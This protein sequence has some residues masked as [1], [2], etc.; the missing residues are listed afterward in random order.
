MFSSKDSQDDKIYPDHYLIN[1]CKQYLPLYSKIKMIKI[2]QE[3]VNEYAFPK[4]KIFQ[5]RYS[6][7][8]L[9]V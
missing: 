9:H 1:I 2:L 7:K 3:K 8:D 6:K 4:N 5:I